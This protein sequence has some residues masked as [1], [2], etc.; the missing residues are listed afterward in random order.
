MFNCP[1]CGAATTS[2]VYCQTCNDLLQAELEAAEVL[3]FAMQ[4]CIDH[5]RVKAGLQPYVKAHLAEA[6][7]EDAETYEI[8]VFVPEHTHE[9]LLSVGEEADGFS[10]ITWSS[11]GNT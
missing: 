3:D 8:K 4:W 7:R 10:V 11:E 9:V 5:F 6:S 1:R 2:G